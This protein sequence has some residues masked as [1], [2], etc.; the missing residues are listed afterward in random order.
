MHILLLSIV[1]IASDTYQ[2]QLVAQK[3]NTA[4]LSAEDLCFLQPS[5]PGL[6]HQ[7]LAK[8][9]FIFEGPCSAPGSFP[10]LWPSHLTATAKPSSC[11]AFLAPWLQVSAEGAAFCQGW[12]QI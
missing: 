9:I 3:T 12:G 8:D 6:P 5:V 11:S 1:F 4:L 10:R 2:L 7:L